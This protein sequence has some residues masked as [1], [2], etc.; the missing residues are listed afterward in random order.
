MDIESLATSAIKDSISWTDR[1]VPYIPE[2]EKEPIW[3][4]SVHVYSSSIHSNENEIGRVPTQ[5]KGKTVKKFKPSEF[6]D[7]PVCELKSYLHEGGSIFFVVELSERTEQKKIFYN[8]LLPYDLVKLIESAGQQI[9]KRITLMPF[10]TSSTDKI[11]IFLDFLSGR[12]KQRSTSN[13]DRIISVEE[14]IKQGY[15]LNL[16]FSFTSSNPRKDFLDQFISRGTYLYFNTPYGISFPVEHFTNVQSVSVKLKTPISCCGTVYYNQ[17]KHSRKKHSSEVSFGRAF[18]FLIDDR[19]ASITLN[20]K[21]A[22]TLSERITDC[23]FILALFEEGGFHF[24]KSFLPFDCTNYDS[25][26]VED[27]KDKLNFL[28]SV[29]SALDVMGVIEDLDCDKLSDEDVK[30]IRYWLLPA[31]SGKSAHIESIEAE[32]QPVILSVCNLTILLMA[33]KQED[34]RYLLKNFFE[35]NG[36]F[37]LQADDGTIVPASCYVVL[38][39]TDF[40][41]LSNINYKRMVTNLIMEMPHPMYCETVNQVVLNLLSAY[42]ETSRLEL[43]QTAK[44][45][46]EWLCSTDQNSTVFHLN[47][48]QSIKRERILNEQELLWLQALVADL[49]TSD[50]NKLGAYILLED[51]R[52]ALECYDKL[53]PKRR[54]EFTEYPI[55]ALWK[56]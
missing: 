46:T 37:I 44:A 31:A 47:L 45:L 29:K 19:K 13:I 1:L 11:D 55:M 28:K 20:I 33:I 9:S 50:E 17:Y 15:P 48:L 5:V 49:A 26:M 14:F 25:G 36:S 30:K 34:G 53:S 39:K 51:Y 22:G 42:D 6:Y 16:S 8:S 41:R 12:K 35:E 24:G 43:L 56:R 40:I 32:Y 23:E 3:D 4:G 27:W 52:S 54:N 21:L 18:H 7:V 2:K 10:P 38:E